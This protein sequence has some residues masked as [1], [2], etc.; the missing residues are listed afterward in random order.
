M[1]RI[2]LHIRGSWVNYNI[3][4][5]IFASSGTIKQLNSVATYTPCDSTCLFNTRHRSKR[6]LV[7]RKTPSSDFFPTKNFSS[8]LFGRSCDDDLA[9]GSFSTGVMVRVWI[10][11]G[12]TWAVDLRLLRSE[13]IGA[14]PEVALD[15]VAWYCCSRSLLLIEKRFRRVKT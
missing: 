11:S 1:A 3:F 8:L 6:S 4:V 7:A 10:V 14:R 9:R 15:A 5:D 13:A 2:Q 12:A